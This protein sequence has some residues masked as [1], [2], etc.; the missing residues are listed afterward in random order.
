MIYHLKVEKDDGTWLITCPALPEVTTFAESEDD[1]ERYALAAVEEA[2]AARISDG[3]DVP[4]P[5][6]V[7]R[8]SHWVWLPLMTSLKV[9]L[10]RTLRESS[11]IPT[12]AELARRM[13]KPR[14]QVDRLFRL[15]HQSRTDQI[16]SAFRA[17][18]KTVDIKI[19]ATR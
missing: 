8:G 17:L 3:R 13:K 6:Q 9:N 7:F 11:D 18:R 5:S 12:R 2:I 10:Y 1:I 19:D 15:D 4:A 14:E 16:E